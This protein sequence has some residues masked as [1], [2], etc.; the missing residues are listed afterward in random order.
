MNK[1]DFVH[2]AY[3]SCVFEMSSILLLNLSSYK[4]DSFNNN[5]KYFL[6]DTL[7]NALKVLSCLIFKKKSLMRSV[8]LLLQHQ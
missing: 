5:T 8:P 6:C 7:L 1:H 4:S 3:T 2:P